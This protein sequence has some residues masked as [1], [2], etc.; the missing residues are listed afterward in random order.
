MTILLLTAVL[1]GFIKEASSA[2][3]LAKHSRLQAL[4]AKRR[5]KR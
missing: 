3:R 2:Q 4:L 5:S 1:S